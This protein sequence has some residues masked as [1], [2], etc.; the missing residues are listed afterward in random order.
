MELIVVKEISY[1]SAFDCIYREFVGSKQLNS[2][3]S[4]KPNLNNPYGGGTIVI[5]GRGV[6]NGKESFMN[7]VIHFDEKNRLCEMLT[8]G[9]TANYN[10]L[11][12]INKYSKLKWSENLGKLA[13]H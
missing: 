1:I 13:V 4:I 2:V 12:T 10:L 11:P 3:L 7:A 5:G 9:D 6:M 8:F